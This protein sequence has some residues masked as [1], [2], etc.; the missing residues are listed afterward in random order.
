MTAS[1]VRSGSPDL[2]LF[3]LQGVIAV[4]SDADIVIWDPSATQR[5]SAK[6]HQQRCDFSVFEGLQCRGAPAW[7]LARGRLCLEEGHLRVVQGAGK[8]LSRAA[9]PPFLYR[10][11]QQR[12]LAGLPAPV[13]RD[14]G[15]E[16]AADSG[17]PIVREV[18]GV[19]R[20]SETMAGRPPRETPVVAADEFHSRSQPAEGVRNQQNSGFAVSGRWSEWLGWTNYRG[21]YGCIE[22]VLAV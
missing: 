19:K 16:D 1:V 7:V 18:N 6:T 15:N 11:V 12:D 5:L 3:L 2:T 4:G 10:R 13:N 20:V 14:G 17:M 8:R 21:C 9:F 22:S